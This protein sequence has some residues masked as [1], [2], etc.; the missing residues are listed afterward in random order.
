MKI[1]KSQFLNPNRNSRFNIM[2]QLKEANKK[3]NSVTMEKVSMMEYKLEHDR[4]TIIRLRTELA[5][6]NNEISMLKAIKNKKTEENHK[7][8][9]IIKSILKQ[10]DKS[11]TSGIIAIE[12][13]LS[14]PQI[15][16]N[17]MDIENNNVLPPIKEMLHFTPAHKQIMKDI[18]YTSKIKDTINDLNEELIKKDEK[19]KELKINKNLGKS[20]KLKNMLFNN[21]DELMEAKR[22]NEI[23]KIRVE[24]INHKIKIEKEDNINLKSKF[25]NFKNSYKLYKE[26]TMEKT[27]SLENMLS[28][29][30]NRATNCKIFHNNEKYNTEKSLIEQNMEMEKIIEN[31]EKENKEIK[32]MNE[33]LEKEN[34]EIKEKNESLEKENNEIKE[35]NES[36]VNDLQIKENLIEEEKNK[37]NVIKELLKQKEEINKKLDEKIKYLEEKIIELEKDIDNYK[38]QKI[39]EPLEKL[40]E[41]ME[42]KIEE[43]KINKDEMKKDEIKKDE[44]NKDEIKKN[45]LNK[46]GIKKDEINRTVSKKDKTKRKKTKR[47][48]TK[49]DEIKKDEI[50]K[51]GKKLDEKQK[52]QI[53][54]DN[55][56]KDQINKDEIKKDEKQ[57]V[58][59]DQDEKKLDENQKDEI[60]KDEIKRDEIQKNEINKEE[61]K[62][63]EIKNNE[64]QKDEKQEDEINKN[65]INKD[66][67]NK[68]EINKGEVKKDEINID[69]IQKNET[70]K[71]EI[72]KEEINKV[73]IKKDEVNKDEKQE[74]EINKNE[75]NKDEINKEEIKKEEINKHEKQEDEINKSKIINDEKNK[76][77]IIKDEIPKEINIDEIDKDKITKNDIQKNEA[78]EDKINKD[79]T[80]KDEINKGEVQK[81]INKDEIDKD[82]GTK[83]EIQKNETNEDKINKD[84]TNKEEINKDEI[85]KD[86][87]Q[88]NETDEYEIQ[89]D[90]TNKEEIKINENKNINNNENII[91]E[92]DKESESEINESIKYIKNIFW[93]DENAESIENQKYFQLLKNK[94][95]NIRLIKTEKDLFKK[96]RKKKFEIGIVIL[97]AK[98]F[99]K[100]IDYLINNSIYYIPISIIFAEND[101]DFKENIDE[102]YKNYLED[103]FYNPLGISTTIENI[104]KKIKNYLNKYGKEIETINLGDSSDPKE[105]NDCYSFEYVDNENKFILPYLFNE[106]M[107][108]AKIE[109][110][111]M[112][113]MNKFLLEN[114]GKNEEIKNLIFP[115]LSLNNIPYNIIAKFWGRIYTL[116]CPFYKNIN[117][118]LI[119]LENQ[120]YN[121]YIRVFY[122]GLQEFKYK[123]NETLFRGANI[124]DNEIDSMID[125]YNNRKEND[126]SGEFQPLYL[127]YSKSYLTFSKDKTLS[128]EAIKDIEKSKKILFQ[129]KNN[130]ENQIINNAYLNEI[131]AIQ[132]NNDI[133]FYPFSSFII[134]KINKIDDI[135]YIDLINYGVYE[136]QIKTKIETIKTEMLNEIINSTNFGNDVIK[137]AIIPQEIENNS[138]IASN[139]QNLIN[140]IIQKNKD[141]NNK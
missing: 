10:C 103:E 90:E 4:E 64:I 135:Y 6:K 125:F 16:N 23:M 69:E 37:A 81:I 113:E 76:D 114:F 68:I 138:N 31:L 133:V 112:K 108:N 122:K 17:K 63:E 41:N 43:N 28:K 18:V 75:L 67:I 89:K 77:E 26:K 8:I 106:I 11:T 139:E 115:L 36:I 2:N 116:E 42:I 1:S 117:N 27:K 22:K 107:Q 30:K 24:D 86:V 7:T 44:I 105:Y 110:K 99:P 20:Y 130:I 94:F 82:E 120:K 34:N 121:T 38:N 126:N 57:K 132:N 140:Y 93:L 53:K 35:K 3:M 60:N 141:S 33:N 45:E 62:K 55:M 123:D 66:E 118:N 119:K 46:E 124:S 49:K 137:S 104:I 9:R 127:L 102:K 70:Q 87:I 129:L 85:T 39:N 19:I 61:I 84:E 128:L 92:E 14:N 78:N 91:K 40:D 32:E 73:E 59:I 51:D 131:S 25:K 13:N 47:D 98:S 109:Y 56:D 58:E 71:D 96:I 111:E 95:K 65:K 101:S 52:D 15:D 136:K 134:D 29:F 48:K 83:N 88:K 80:N 72:N 21:F 100:Y 12:N 50:N 79:E 97:N 5:S 54:K 74:D